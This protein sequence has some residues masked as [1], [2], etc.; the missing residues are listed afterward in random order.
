MLDVSKMS[1]DELMQ[2]LGKPSANKAP[3]SMSDDEL[4]QALGKAPQNTPKGQP[5]PANT[6][7]RDL[8]TVDEPSFLKSF[9]GRPVF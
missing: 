7:V 2:A 1:D 6:P 4:L 9:G 3:S 8:Y 5:L